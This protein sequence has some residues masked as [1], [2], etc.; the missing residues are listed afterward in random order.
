M[1][2]FAKCPPLWANGPDVQNM[3]QFPNRP[4][5]PGPI[6]ATQSPVTTGR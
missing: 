3:H 2:N 1:N 6:R 5:E 4:M